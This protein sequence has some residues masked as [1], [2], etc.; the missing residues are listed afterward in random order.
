VA[1]EY[2]LGS[3]RRLTNVVVRG[4]LRTPL[5]PP[6][7]YLLSVRGRRTGRVY[8]TPVWLIERPGDRWLVAPYG[9]VS[10]V[11]NARAQ[12]E[13]TLGRR[14]WAQTV[15][16]E[17]LAPAESVPILREYLQKA[18]VVRPFF[19]VK[20]DALFAVF[21]EEAPRHPVFRI[22]D[23]AERPAPGDT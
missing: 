13:V 17:E 3:M 20:P 22:R 4:L 1:R 12:G 2:R 23:A 7:T 19:D 11:K 21:V 9:E 5:A 16:V 14:R 6:H 15:A 8:S 10:W 18:P